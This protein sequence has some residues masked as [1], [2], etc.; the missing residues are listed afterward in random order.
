MIIILFSLKGLPLENAYPVFVQICQKLCYFI[1][2]Y[3]CMFK[4]WCK[5]FWRNS[6]NT[7]KTVGAC[8]ITIFTLD[9]PT[10]KVHWKTI[11]KNGEQETTIGCSKNI[12]YP[13][14]RFVRRR[15]LA[16][17]KSQREGGLGLALFFR[18]SLSRDFFCASQQGISHISTCYQARLS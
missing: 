12:S 13:Q 15:R 16:G 2:E 6:R 17:V 7:R 11:E 5:P 9:L 1:H 8:S 10:N 14:E 3:F 18:P 4:A